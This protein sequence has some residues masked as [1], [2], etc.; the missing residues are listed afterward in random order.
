MA[1]VGVKNRPRNAKM[2]KFLK[3]QNKANK[4]GFE[5]NV[6]LL[7][8]SASQSR[9]EQLL[10]HLESAFAQ[11]NAPNLNGLKAFR[12]KGLALKRLI[13]QFTFRLFNKK[14]SSILNTEELTGLFHFPSAG[15]ETPKVKFIKAEAAAAPAN[16]PKEGVILGKNIYR[17]IE[18]IVRI[19]RDDRR[20][21]LY[22]ICQTGTGKSGFLKNMIVQDIKTGEGVGVLDPHGDLIG[23][24]LV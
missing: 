4:V 1:G 22:V 19:K 17:G 23:E 16:L 12:L 6:R 21:H 5:T 11:F 15:L 8:S 2:E 20:R 10:G 9:A 24:T 13:Y 14:Q 7:V 18:T 3:S